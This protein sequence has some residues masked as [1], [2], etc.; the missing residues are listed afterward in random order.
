MF[1]LGGSRG[2]GGGRGGARG[3]HT[4]YNLTEILIRSRFCLTFLL[5]H[6]FKMFLYCTHPST[7]CFSFS[8]C[9]TERSH[10]VEE[11]KSNPEQSNPPA[12]LS[13]ISLFSG[14]AVFHRCSFTS[15]GTGLETLISTEWSSFNSS[16][17]VSVS[18]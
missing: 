7:T 12:R 11:V 15:S 17:V 9:I 14:T 4:W 6:F 1:C 8:A 13:S 16:G 10:V 18:S 3:R 2:R 5:F